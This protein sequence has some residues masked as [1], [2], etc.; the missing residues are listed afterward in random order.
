[1]GDMSDADGR[2][3]LALV[4]SLTGCAV[5][6]SGGATSDTDAQ[7]ALDELPARARSKF[8]K[9]RYC[10]FF[11]TRGRCRKRHRCTFAHSE[12]ELRPLPDLR[13]TKMCPSVAAGGKCA[14]ED[15]MYAHSPHELRT[16]EAECRGGGPLEPQQEPHRLELAET[17]GTGSGTVE[18]DEDLGIASSAGAFQR[19]RTDDPAAL[20]VYVMRVKN[21]CIDEDD[22]EGKPLRSK[23]WL[24]STRAQGATEALHAARAGGTRGAGLAAL[25]QALPR[26]PPRAPGGQA[27]EPGRRPVGEAGSLGF[28]TAA[29][30]P[31]TARG[32]VAGPGATK[33]VGGTMV[34][35]T[36]RTPPAMRAPPTQ[37]P[38]ASRPSAGA[39]T[40]RGRP[41][42]LGLAG[43]RPA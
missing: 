36:P 30:G 5:S 42:R 7:E 8:L 17:K 16:L 19:Q 28:G 11:F 14:Q 41:S 40:A 2:P 32:S 6:G 22:L 20:C 15:C 10:E 29:S 12:A 21:T 24:P 4:D 27:S 23:S 31:P 9:T 26:A 3:A 18:G 33:R 38:L 35:R 34:L 13:F 37:A 39:P 1:A 43:A 25:P